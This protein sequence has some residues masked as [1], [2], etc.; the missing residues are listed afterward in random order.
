MRRISFYILIIIQILLIAI[1]KII[2]YKVHYE[3]GWVDFGFDFMGCQMFFI[4]FFIA[5]F[6]F[7]IFI[8]EKI[9]LKIFIIILSIA[10]FLIYNSL[11]LYP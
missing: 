10:G 1:A 9:W 3:V 8:K 4:L 7:A 11:Y 2:D 6:F 5:S